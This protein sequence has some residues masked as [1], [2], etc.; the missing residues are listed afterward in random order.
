VGSPGVAS[1]MSLNSALRW[2]V[3][4]QYASGVPELATPEK[5]QLPVLARRLH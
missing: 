4:S 2:L 1:G 5:P 3:K